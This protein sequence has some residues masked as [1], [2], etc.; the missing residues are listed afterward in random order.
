[1]SMNG[2]IWLAKHAIGELHKLARKNF[3]WCVSTF[4]HELYISI[5]LKAASQLSQRPS[6]RDL[7]IVVYNMD[8]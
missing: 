2:A 8:K 5:L 6:S 1:M 4:V 3:S 7:Q